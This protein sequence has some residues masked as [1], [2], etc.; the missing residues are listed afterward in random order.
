MNKIIKYCKNSRNSELEALVSS[1]NQLS[2]ELSLAHV[3][4]IFSW[5]STDPSLAARQK[6]DDDEVDVR[7]LAEDETPNPDQQIEETL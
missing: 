7:E 4:E 5:L 2:T 6:T 1:D 3:E